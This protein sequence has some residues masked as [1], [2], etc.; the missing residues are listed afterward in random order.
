MQS[1]L[2]AKASDGTA[3]ASLMTV[4]TLRSPGATTILVNTVSGVPAGGFFASMGAPHTFTDPITSEVITIISDATAVDFAGHIN[5]GQ[6]IIDAIAPG[7]ADT[8]GSA[9]GDIVVIRPVTEWTNNFYNILNASHT[10]NGAIK[11][12]EGFLT[13]G[14]IVP[15]IASNNLVLAIKTLAGVDPS[16]ID[17]VYVRI[18]DTVRSIT[19]ALSVTTAAGTNWWGKGSAPLGGLPTWFYAYLGYN[20]TDGVVLGI[21]T[22]A[23]G[24]KY[25]DFS[26]TNTDWT[27]AKISTITNA[28][29]TDVY[30]NIGR[31]KA[32]LG[33]SATYLWTLPTGV[34]QTILSQ[35]ARNLATKP[36]KF[37]VFL[38]NGS[39]NSGNGAFVKIGMDT[40]KYDL[41]NDVDIVTNV[42][43]F[44]API[45]GFYDMSAVCSNGAGTNM[46][47]TSLYKNGAEFRRGGK[48]STG[49]N[50]SGAGSTV[51]CEMLLIAGDY[52]E[53]WYYSTSVVALEGGSGGLIAFNGKITQ[54]V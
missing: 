38:N 51:D 44:T 37:S 6:V 41:H 15:S 54:E 34:A 31:F 33:V 19:A 14:K 30:E 35:P 29:A 13:N 48:L 2:Y 46:A 5:A 45:T 8:R 42:G 49:S 20:T 21:S 18:G 36:I 50:N 11:S 16:A 23:D 9:V 12:P 22:S 17:P 40:K 1:I 3:N 28:A 7:Y 47:I 32:I 27:Y 25:A 10:D 24:Y 43:R 4:Q 39:V 52:V 26:T 53:V